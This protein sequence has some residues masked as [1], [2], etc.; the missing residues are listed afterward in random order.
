MKKKEEG[1]RLRETFAIH[2]RAARD[3]RRVAP[4]CFAPF[5]L[6]AA[7]NAVS[8]YAVIWLFAR[9]IDEL[10]AFRRPELLGRWVFW[11]VAVSA[12]T[13]LLK[14]VLER[15]KNVRSELFDKQD[16]TLYTEKFLRMDYADCDRQE[17]RDLFSQIRQNANWSGW[18][19]THLKLYYTQ[20]IQGVTG[21]LGADACNTQQRD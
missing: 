10:S 11:I 16:E 7:V 1:M 9:L 2:R 4:G 21:I 13:E 12:A 19:F 5:I 18:G 20:A 17:T 14:A 6:C 8:P 15:W 3:M